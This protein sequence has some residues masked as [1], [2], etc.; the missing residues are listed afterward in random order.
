[1]SEEN[2]QPENDAAEAT[3]VTEPLPPVTKLL[4]ETFGDN[5]LGHSNRLGEETVSIARKDML[6]LMRF[7]KED[8]RCAFN[9]MVDLT[10]VDLQPATPRFEVVYHFK[11]I[12]RGQRLRVKVPVAEDTAEAAGVDS[13]RGLWIAADW[14]ERE[15]REMYGIHF[16]G[17]PD[18]RPLLLYDGFEGYPLR[19]DYD[20]GR[21]QPLV[22]LRPIRERYDYGEHFHPV[23][24]PIE[25]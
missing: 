15:A 4:M 25:N 23:Q 11:S 21:A 8:P 10:A 3:P 24:Q 9:M 22:P 2:T 18:L 12:G 7:L 5:V 17:H 16:A 19:K 6:T 14:Y 20:K 13:I 1:M